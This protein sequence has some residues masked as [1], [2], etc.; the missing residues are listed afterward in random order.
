MTA[1]IFNTNLH[2]DAVYRK[3]PMVQ[4]ILYQLCFASK[5]A[6]YKEYTKIRRIQVITGFAVAQHCCN[7]DQQS[8]WENEDFDPL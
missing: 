6:K 3:C 2:I 8:Q 1:H 5:A 7:D 4:S